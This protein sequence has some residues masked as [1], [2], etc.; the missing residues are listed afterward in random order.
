MISVPSSRPTARVSTHKY[1]KVALEKADPGACGSAG[2]RW[3]RAG[4]RGAAGRAG[5]ARKR[6][7]RSPG[8]K[9]VLLSRLAL[10]VVLPKPPSALE[11]DPALVG[12][13]LG[14]RGVPGRERH[15]VASGQVMRPDSARVELHHLPKRQF[16]AFPEAAAMARRWGA[17]WLPT[18]A[19]RPSRGA[20]ARPA[21]AVR[22]QGPFRRGARATA[23]RHP[24][25]SARGQAQAKQRWQGGSAAF[26][27]LAGSTP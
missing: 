1:A 17:T 24:A 22:P 27:E 19:R 4:C 7:R 9:G 16:C 12:P 18:R 2:R 11:S 8:T 21:T 3:Q 6:H 23:K 20:R 5:G 10:G 14:L 26:G 13:L 25:F 15:G